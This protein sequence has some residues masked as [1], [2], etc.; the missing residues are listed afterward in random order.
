MAADLAVID[1]DNNSDGDGHTIGK[2]GAASR[3]QGA[4][5]LM[6]DQ[7]PHG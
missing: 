2:T 5:G 7:V 1:L 4:E 3:Q 6:P